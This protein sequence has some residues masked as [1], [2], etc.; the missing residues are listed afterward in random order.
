[1]KTI[2]R[3]SLKEKI[4]GGDFILL[5]VL[6]EQA[7]TRGH[8]PGAIRYQGKD[9]IPDLLPNKATEVIAYCSNFN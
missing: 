6:S 2:N 1:V 3:E 8:L 9:M 4:D 7:Y 5:E